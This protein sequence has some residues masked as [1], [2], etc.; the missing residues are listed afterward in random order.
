MAQKNNNGEYREIQILSLFFLFCAIIA[1]V[2]LFRL[3]VLQHDYYSTLAMSS[4]EIYQKLHP[5]RGEIFYS[6]QKGAVYPAAMNRVYYRLYGVPLEIP[7]NDVGEIAKKLI[8]IIQPENP[9]EILSQ[10]I[11]R[12]SKENDP[13][14]PIAEKISEEVLNKIKEENLK[15]I[16][17][18]PETYRYYPEEN[19]S[20]AVLGFCSFDED[21]NLTGQYGAE[22]YWNKTLA[23]KPG[24]FMGEKAAQG[25]WI[26]LAGMTNVEAENGADIVLTIDRALQYKACLRLAEGLKAFNARSASLVMLDPATGA[27]LALC[28][29]PDY[30][31]NNYSK[32]G[33]IKNYN[34][35]AIFNA[36]EIG[37]VFKPIVMSVGIDLGLVGPQTTFDDPCERQFDKYTIRNALKKCYGNNVTMTAVLENSINTGMIWLAERIKTDRLKT[38]LEKF[39]FGQKTGIPLDMEM[40]GNIS[41]LQKKSPIYTAQASFGQ[42]ITATTMQLALAYSAIASD[43]K[44]PAPYLIKEIRHANGKV[45]KFEPKIVAQVIT[46]RAAKLTAGMLTSVVE[47]SYVN[48]VRL[49]DYYVA[50]KTGTAQ[51]AGPGGYLEN[52]TNHTFAGF[53][54]A[55]NPRVVMVVHYEMPER[56]WAESTA[57]I[58][59]KDVAEFAMD[60]LGVEKDKK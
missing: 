2:Q 3:Q 44:L 43:G 37:S 42:G 36:Y 49:N 48:S 12:L 31:P 51:I 5:R 10:W 33:S 34:N 38:Y 9:E 55:G 14:E 59:F 58:I 35:N 40:A 41:S 53:V 27:V 19:S 15:G 24:F 54:P 21:H 30:D 50:G 56:Q 32:A 6:D 20:A 39:G 17:G 60:Y 22:G 26:S 47:K 13:Y 16:Y 7:I 25:G 11:A 57:A 46:P 18:T 29:L 28:S 23:G 8:E 4:H 1:G 45:E 52:V